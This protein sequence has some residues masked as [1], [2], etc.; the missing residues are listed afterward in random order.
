MKSPA[1]LARRWAKQWDVADNR[2]RRLLVPESWPVSLSIGKPTPA[3]FTRH[4][5]RVR[6]HLQRWRAV[7]VGRVVWEQARFR[8][9]SEPVDLPVEWVLTSPTDWAMA[10]SDPNIQNE[11]DRLSRLVS[12]TNSLFHRS[13]VRQRHLLQDKSDEEVLKAIEVTMA[14]SPGDASGRPLRA[15]SICGIDSKFWERHRSLLVHLLD[16]RFD[17]QVSDLGLEAFLGAL[18]EGEHWL[19]IAPLADG[20]LPFAQQRV[21]ARELTATPLPGSHVLIVENERCLHQLPRLPDTV[22]VL[23]A[24]L[25]LAWMDAAWLREKRVA[26]WGDIDTWGLVML[27]G[28]RRRQSHVQPLL[29]NIELFEAIRA[30]AAV[31]E[32]RPAGEEPPTELTDSEQDLYRL[33][34]GLVRGRV[35]QEFVPRDR[36]LAELERWRRSEM[37]RCHRA[38]Q[39]S[40]ECM[41]TEEYQASG[42]SV[43]CARQTEST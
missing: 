30:T 7:K 41:I 34:R 27:A 28:A 14:L 4:T 32:S 38:D 18:D 39:E 12:A 13:L 43:S 26:Y 15:L 1:E 11:Y 20:L 35:E 29:M 5:D 2:E 31:V 19:L 9:G 42:S 21:R 23:G 40:Q 17:G 25:N 37:N 8:G 24:G 3:Q 16:V 6:A 10:C 36:V 22:A 33:L